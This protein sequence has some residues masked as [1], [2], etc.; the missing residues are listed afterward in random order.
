MVGLVVY[1]GALIVDSY[2]KLD[3]EG[4]EYVDSNAMYCK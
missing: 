2:L 1:A 3:T 4:E